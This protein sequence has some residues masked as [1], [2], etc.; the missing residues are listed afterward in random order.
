M[1]RKD[2]I[3]RVQKFYDE[4]NASYRETLRKSLAKAGENEEIETI[5]KRINEIK[6]MSLTGAATKET[7]KE[8]ATLEERFRSLVKG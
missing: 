5:R 7:D 6:A 3:S 4:R 2:I 1:L 8:Y